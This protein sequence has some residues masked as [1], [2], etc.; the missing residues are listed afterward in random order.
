MSNAAGRVRVPYW[1]VVNVPAASTVRVRVPT[2]YVFSDMAFTNL[3]SSNIGI[4]FSKDREQRSYVSYAAAD[5]EDGGLPTS[6]DAFTNFVF[7]DNAQAPNWRE[8]ESSRI[9]SIQLHN[10]SGFSAENIH[11]YGVYVKD[12][13]V[14]V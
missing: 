1:V 13:C 11:L 5:L 7:V 2:G 12:V 6:F 3:A 9:Q 8:I 4:S 14:Q 10:A